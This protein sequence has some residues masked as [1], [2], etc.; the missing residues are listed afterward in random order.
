MFTQFQG[1]FSDNALKWLVIF[2]ILGSG[3]SKG[4]QDAMTSHA[5]TLFAVPFLLFSAASGWLADRVSKRSVM[6][7]VKLAEIAIMFFAA[8][9]LALG[10][11]VMQLAAICLMGLHS[12]FFAPA[13]YGIIPEMVPASQLS[14]ANGI[15]EMLTFVAIILGTVTGGWLAEEMQGRQMWSGILLAALAGFGLLTA[16][17]V[18]AVP[19][20]DPQKPFRINFLADLWTQFSHMRKDRDLW[21]ANLGNTAFFYIAALVQ[22]NLALFAKQDFGMEPKQQSWL[23]AALCLGIGAGSVLA[24]KLS[25]GTIAYGLLPIGAGLMTLGGIAL[26]WPGI[27]V[28][29]FAAAL[30]VLGIGGGL[31]IVPVAA[32]LQ[33]RAPAAEKGGVQAAA[34]WLSW[35]GIALAAMTPKFLVAEA[36]ETASAATAATA[37]AAGHTANAFSLGLTHGQIFFV[38]ALC[39]GILA[40]YC[41][42]SRPGALRA[43]LRGNADQ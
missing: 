38:G 17:R 14:R 12:T 2:L 18:P 43:L 33:H 27:G 39:S 6:V 32:V 40:L 5:G 22:L 4:E 20:A 23:Q 28:Y 8:A 24:G 35:V 30:A 19:A 1:A 16:L 10:S 7:G 15:L 25:R 41:L 26:G 3:L 34:S 29:P 37:E 11:T 36:T 13:K 21:R 42:K 9:G 31:F